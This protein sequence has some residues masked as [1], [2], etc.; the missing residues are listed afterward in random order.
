MRNADEVDSAVTRSVSILSRL[1]LTEY[2]AR[3]YVALLRLGSATAREVSEISEVPRTKVYE[4]MERLRDRGLVDVQNGKPK[5]FV[6]L[7]KQATTARFRRLLERDIN[8]LSAALDELE[9]TRT[10]EE[11]TGVWATTGTT[12]VDER[13]AL[14]IEDAASNVRFCCRSEYASESVLTQLTA[15]R[16]RGVDLAVGTI[17]NTTTDRLEDRFADAHHIGIHDDLVDDLPTR[18]L[19]VDDE[20]ALVATNDHDDEQ[21][22]WSTDP[23]N[24]LVVLTRAIFDD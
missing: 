21:A 23:Q 24:P 19:L 22:V 18:L 11:P 6:P 16:E 3:T 9:T 5:Q 20:A 17:G 4:E 13:L 15:A 2:S 7:T 14:V 1:G 12:T 10:E 8:S